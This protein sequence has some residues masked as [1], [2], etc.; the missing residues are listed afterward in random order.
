M[1]KLIHLE[2]KKA[3][4]KG[5]MI[6]SSIACM[7]LIIWCVWNRSG[8]VK[9]YTDYHTALAE[10]SFYTNTTCLIITAILISKMVLN[11][12]RTQTITVLFT[13]PHSRTK[14]LLAKLAFISFFA[15]L[16]AW[17]TNL[18][19]SGVFFFCIPSIQPELGSFT[20][21]LLVLN[22]LRS[23]LFA[24]A[25]I[26]INLISFFFGML[27]KSI[28][29]TI[30]PSFLIVLVIGSNFYHLESVWSILLSTIGWVVLGLLLSYQ[31]IK[32]AK[33]LDTDVV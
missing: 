5:I 18:I 17:L 26:G 6:S 3:Q 27:K 2:Y 1:L 14:I 16:S 8:H 23:F 32:K 29:A 4:L 30:V 25:T 11:E 15:F 31:S 24:V 13:Y 19:V 10:I 28:P 33:Q 7:I 12:Y 21:D 20:K 22:V 9:G